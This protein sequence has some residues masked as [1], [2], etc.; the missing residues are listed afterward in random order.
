MT[1]TNTAGPYVFD[2]GAN[3]S[4]VAGAIAGVGVNL[5]AL[6]PQF[7]NASDSHRSASSRLSSASRGSRNRTP[8]RTATG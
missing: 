7:R 8:E 4:G 1:P 2:G 5:A 3:P 6:V